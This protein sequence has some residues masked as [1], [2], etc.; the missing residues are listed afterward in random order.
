MWWHVHVKQDG[1][2]T[3]FL[4]FSVEKVNELVRTS[5]KSQII[6]RAR[7]QVV[8]VRMWPADRQLD[9][10]GLGRGIKFDDGSER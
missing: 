4:S 1:L 10:A 5:K 2:R 3:T 8:A 6:S 9:D 7:L